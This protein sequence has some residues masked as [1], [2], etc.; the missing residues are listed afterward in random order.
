MDCWTCGNC[1][2]AHFKISILTFLEVDIF[3]N[4]MSNMSAGNSPFWVGVMVS[5]QGASV[6]ELPAALRRPRKKTRPGILEHV[7]CDCWVI[8]SLLICFSKYGR[9]DQMTMPAR[10]TSKFCARSRSQCPEMFFLKLISLVIPAMM[11]PWLECQPEQSWEL[12]WVLGL[13]PCQ[14]LSFCKYTVI[15]DYGFIK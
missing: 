15:W 6:S 9:S 4:K 3:E 11:E 2:Q 8:L 10:R 13:D 5:Q 7:F 12:P 14:Y 1:S